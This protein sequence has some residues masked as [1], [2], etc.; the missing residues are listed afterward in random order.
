[1]QS[2][3][4]TTSN[5]SIA[6]LFKKDEPLLFGNAMSSTTNVASTAPSTP[7]VIEIPSALGTRSPCRRPAGSDTR[8]TL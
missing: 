5:P 2:R 3:A 1:M 6:Q 8:A 4:T 7:Y